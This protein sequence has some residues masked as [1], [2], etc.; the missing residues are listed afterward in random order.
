M[1]HVNMQY[2]YYKSS[3]KDSV[4]REVSRDIL[5]IN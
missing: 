4:K 2:W 1:L 5:T 3:F